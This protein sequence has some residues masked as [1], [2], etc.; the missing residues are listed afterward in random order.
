M[1]PGFYHFLTLA[2]A[3]YAITSAWTGSVLTFKLRRWINDF[4]SLEGED[5]G[6]YDAASCFLC[7]AF[8]FTFFVVAIDSVLGQLATMPLAV[9]GL[10]YWLR[11]MQPE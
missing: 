10:A 8:W 11:T 6:Q 1:S 4:L 9:Y 2:F 3:V 5:G 7:T